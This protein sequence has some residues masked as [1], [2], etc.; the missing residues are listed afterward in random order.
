MAREVQQTAFI[1]HRRP[2]RET[3]LLLT[4]FTPEEGKLNAIA[5]GVKGKS[6]SAQAKQAWCQPFQQLQVGWV[7]KSTQNL[8][9]LVSLRQLEP[10]NVRFP[11]LG[12][13]NICGLYI[14]ELLYRLLYPHVA[15]PSL[16]DSYQQTLF[17]LA[18]SQN[19]QD[20][21]W[22]LRQF[23]YELLMAMGYA[24]L[25]D[26]DAH[27]NPIQAENIYV[28]Y[29]ETGAF[30]LEREGQ[31][32]QGIQI[33]GE[34]LLKFAQFER[35]DECLGQWKKLFRRIL[36]HYLGDKPIQTRALFQ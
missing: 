27:H 19:R 34:C 13:S 16:Y 28:F 35:C 7:E 2:Y 31:N 5:K 24:V 17:D 10:T 32:A 33:S 15:M 18:K 14:N 29:P 21:A 9:A 22:V 36:A 20:Q 6:K 23:E 1:L 8:P 3:S 4:L 26:E 12:E 11:L 30:P 25:L